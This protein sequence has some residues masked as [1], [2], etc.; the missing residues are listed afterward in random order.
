MQ[1]L[2]IVETSRRCPTR[3]DDAATHSLSCYPE[4]GVAQAL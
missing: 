2:R 4:P 1:T 3:A